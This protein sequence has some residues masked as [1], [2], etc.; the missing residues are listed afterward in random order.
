MIL[1]LR[2]LAGLRWEIL[3]LH[4]VPTEFVKCSSPGGRA[5]AEGAGW[6]H[7]DAL[8]GAGLSRDCGLELLLMG[9][10]S[11]CPFSECSDV[12]MSLSS[13]STVMSSTIIGTIACTP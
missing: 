4:L 13:C 12:M 6:C 1:G 11:C 8:A 10:P 5:G 2:N 9:S 7:S 3:T